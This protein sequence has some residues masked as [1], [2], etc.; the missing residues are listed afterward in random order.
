MWEGVTV[1]AERYPSESPLP[2]CLGP[3]GDEQQS[4]MG[5][6]LAEAFVQEELRIDE[7]SSGHQVEALATVRLASA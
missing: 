7:S 1:D 3:E 5:A 2:V 6:A 4:R